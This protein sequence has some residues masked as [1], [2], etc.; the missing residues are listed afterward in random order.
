M[1]DDSQN[2]AAITLSQPTFYQLNAGSW[3]AV[4][5]LPDIT[6]T[7]E[8]VSLIEKKKRHRDQQRLGTR[9]LLKALL[10]SL[11]ISDELVETSFPYRLKKSGAFVCFSHSGNQVAVAISHHQPIGLDIEAQNISWQVAKRYYHP[12]EITELSKLNGDYRQAISR[13]LWQIKESLIKIEQF[14]L[15][16][17][18]GKDYSALILPIQNALLKKQTTFKLPI[19]LPKNKSYEVRIILK[20]HLAVIF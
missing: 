18:L 13:L 20:H 10:N 12:N 11:H 4:A 8:E 3:C 15:A 6:E 2:K 5:T 19:S 16:Q 17:G 1:N 7:L 9:Q 14:T